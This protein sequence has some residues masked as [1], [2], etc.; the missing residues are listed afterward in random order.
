MLTGA[1]HGTTHGTTRA[2]DAYTF[3]EILMRAR[4]LLVVPALLTLTGCV[5]E[6]GHIGSAVQYSSE[7]VEMDDSEVVRV[8]LKMGAGDLRITDGGAKLMRGDFAYSVPSWKPQVR[9]NR[10]G[11]QGSLTIEQ[12]VS[13]HARLGNT[14]YN[15]DLQLNKKAPVDLALH[16]GAGQARLDLGSLQLRGVEVDMGVG[17]LDMDLRGAPKHSYDVSI[18]GGIGEATV[19]VSA[20]AGIY[21]Q[22][23]GGIGEIKVRGLR[24]EDGHWVS[25]S[26]DSAANKVRIEIQGGI[27]Q[28]NVIAD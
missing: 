28:V 12:P 23:H 14:K 18:H 10:S 7:S 5:V 17:Q 13:H 26:Y 9:Y 24:R 1:S 16:F 2:L 3:Q 6:V 19:R 11:K 4:Y 8:E 22:A 21:A 27:G 25:P 15:W 20:D